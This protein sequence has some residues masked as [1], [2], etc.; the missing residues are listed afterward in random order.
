MSSTPEHN[1]HQ[2]L[3]ATLQADAVSTFGPGFADRVM[4]RLPEQL[5]ATGAAL[6]EVLRP[7]FLRLAVATVLLIGALGTYNAMQYADPSREATVVE[8]VLGLP[9]VT[10]DDAVGVSLLEDEG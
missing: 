9:S 7:A 1:R 4:D 2:A 8:S 6:Y 5:D 3:R 10:L